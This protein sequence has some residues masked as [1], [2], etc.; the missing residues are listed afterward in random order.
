MSVSTDG[1]RFLRCVVVTVISMYFVKQTKLPEHILRMRH[2]FLPP[3]L[4][5]HI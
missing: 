2:Y 3:K 5:R 1:P 4:I